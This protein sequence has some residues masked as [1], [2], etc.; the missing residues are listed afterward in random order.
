MPFF[1]AKCLF[2]V[3]ISLKKLTSPLNI[4]NYLF[5]KMGFL[6]STNADMPSFWSSVAK[7]AWKTRRSN[8][9]TKGISLKPPKM[10]WGPPFIWEHISPWETRPTTKHCTPGLVDCP[11]C[12]HG[13]W[14][15]HWTPLKR[16]IKP[17]KINA[18][19]NWCARDLRLRTRLL[20][21][22]RE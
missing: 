7:H 8:N 9:C 22:T 14:S 20:H 15:I 10:C 19:A 6:F 16:T 18:Y 5:L 21:F 13:R 4:K 3:Q 11:E 17:P 2:L 12:W 1:G